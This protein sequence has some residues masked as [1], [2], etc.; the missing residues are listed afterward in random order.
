LL[1]RLLDRVDLSFPVIV[2]GKGWYKVALDGRHRISKA[3]W[4]GLS[5]LP[6][7]RVPVWF[8]LELLAPGVYEIEWLGLFLGGKLHKR[9]N[10]PST[11]RARRVRVVFAKSD[12]PGHP[13]SKG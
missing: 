8:A 11:S 3:T 4:T 13:T 9:S 10:L 7:V 5:E 6:A 12:Y 2:A 1:P